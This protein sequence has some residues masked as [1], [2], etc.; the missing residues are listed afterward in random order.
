MERKLYFDVNMKHYQ[1]YFY[2]IW[3]CST[4]S[5]SLSVRPPQPGVKRPPPQGLLTDAQKIKVVWNV[6]SF[7]SHWRIE[8]GLKTG[9][10]NY[11]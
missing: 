2:L 8:L 4:F 3:K 6:T 7:C 9:T 11:D 5:N 1:E 10:G